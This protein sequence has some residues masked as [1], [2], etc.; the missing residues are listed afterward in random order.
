MKKYLYTLSILILLSAQGFSTHNRAGEILYRQISTYTFEV[1]LITYTYTPSAANE[2]RDYLNMNWGDGTSDQIKRQSI[3]YLPNDYQKNI[4]IG[5]HTYPG[6]YTY[7]LYMEDPNRNEGIDNISGSVNVVF[8]I[9]TVLQINPVIGSNST[10]VLYNPPYDIAAVGQVFIHNPGAFDPDGDSLSYKLAPCLGPGGEPITGYQYPESSNEPIRVDPLT[11]D[12][13]WNA[14]PRVGKFNVAIQIEEWRKGVKI[15]TILRDI[16]IDVYDTRNN[17]PKIN[18]LPDI[19]V[20]AGET[21]EFNVSATDTDN[22]SITLSASGG[23]LVE[24]QIKINPAT[25]NTVHGRGSVQSTFRWITHP[26]HIRDQPYQII[27]RAEDH[28]IL[29][30]VNGKP[31]FDQNGQPIKIKLAT[32]EQVNIR[33][34]GPEPENLTVE[35]DIRSFL[36]DWEAADAVYPT[37]Y[38]VYRKNNYFGFSPAE[39]E[40]G[41]PAYTGYELLKSVA[42]ITNTSLIDDSPDLV[43]GY[44]YCYMITAV[45]PDGSESYATPEICDDLKRTTPIITNV[46]ITH[47]DNDSGAIYL[48]WLKPDEAELTLYEEPFHYVIWRS[49]SVENPLFTRVAQINGLNNTF[50]NDTLLNTQERHFYYMVDLFGQKAGTDSIIAIGSAARASSLFIEAL[51]GDDTVFVNLKESVPW[52]NYSY[53]I[54]RKKSSEESYILAGKTDSLTFIDDK[55]VNGQT[56]CY[57]A[58][59]YGFYSA[60]DIPKPLLNFSQETCAQPW[61]RT[62]PCPPALTVTPNCDSLR[63]ELTWTN[64]NE[65]CTDDVERYTVYFSPTFDGELDSIAS[66]SPATATSFFHTPLGTLTGCYAVSAFDSLKYNNESERIRVCQPQNC[67]NYALPNFFSP[68][69][70]NLNDLMRPSPYTFVEKVDMKIYNRLGVLVFQTQDPDINWDGKYLNSNNPVTD[71]V[72]YYIC[73][74]YQTNLYGTDVYALT[75]FVHVYASEVNTGF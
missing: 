44:Q 62:P 40:T 65:S 68:N 67:F 58:L 32:F 20:L 2:S 50:F 69:G 27:F 59:S 3:I 46:S 31:I 22:D 4:Y 12:L 49:E 24:D 35:G 43:Q 10:P 28:T 56:Y 45:Y 39:C 14:P 19:C 71:G 48:A 52:T 57:K 34:V 17:P 74:V 64:P 70:D 42:G 15:G 7:E 66:V 30:D 61:D 75:G 6:P 9:K 11:G 1:T 54:F 13:I 33:I 16:Q 73:D 37:G 51:P 23:P 41:V 63:N 60:D 55:V 25:F 8:A 36:I 5:T 26:A 53:E 18:P 72:Y 21:V 38:K 29:T 47:T